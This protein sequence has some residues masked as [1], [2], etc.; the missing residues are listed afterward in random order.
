[1]SDI[2][3]NLAIVRER[4][5]RAAEKSGREAHAIRLIAVTKS[6]PVER[7][8]VA[9]ATGLTEFG[10]NRVQEATEKFAVS[11]VYMQGFDKYTARRS[12]ILGAESGNFY[13]GATYKRADCTK[14]LTQS[15]NCIGA[16]RG[17]EKFGTLHRGV[18]SQIEITNRPT[19]DFVAHTTANQEKPESLLLTRFH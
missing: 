16:G 19:E 12:F 11:Q 17:K 8:K 5:A 7:I 1:M 14:L 15:E 2:A 6:M 3:H 4:I 10:E 9:I 18:S 13:L